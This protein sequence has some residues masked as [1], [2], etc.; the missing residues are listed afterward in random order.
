[1][2]LSVVAN[3]VSPTAEGTQLSKGDV[4]AVEAEGLVEACSFA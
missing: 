4:K 1:M 3:L 2:I